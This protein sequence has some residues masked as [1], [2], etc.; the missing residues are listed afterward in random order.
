MSAT[1]KVLYN[2]MKRSIDL[3]IKYGKINN[4]NY[5]YNITL[6]SGWRQVGGFYLSPVTWNN[7]ITL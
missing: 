1:V 6:I 5:K 4:T 3:A 2:L 7:K